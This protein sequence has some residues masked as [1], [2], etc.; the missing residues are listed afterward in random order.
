ML[1]V[2]SSSCSMDVWCIQG[3]DRIRCNDKQ[4][5]CTNTMHMAG[6]SPETLR[7]QQLYQKSQHTLVWSNAMAQVPGSNPALERLPQLLQT[8][9]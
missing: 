9:V 4:H 5:Q 8:R 3:A 7:C 6:S 1:Q 2:M